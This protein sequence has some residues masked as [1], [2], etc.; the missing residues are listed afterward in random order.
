MTVEVRV[1]RKRT[2][3]IP[4]RVA[5]ALG[6]DEGSRLL[7]EVKS[8]Y[9]IVRPLPD[10]IYLSLHGEK[11]AKVTLRE[12]EETSIEEQEKRGKEA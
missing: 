2:L 5:E 6:I 7:I 9:M 3:V 12:L 11:L 8:G 4:K 1:G 10:A